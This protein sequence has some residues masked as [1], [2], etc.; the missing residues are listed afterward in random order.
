MGWAARASKNPAG[1]FESTTD[2]RKL[3]HYE[4]SQWTAFAWSDPP[5]GM[6]PQAIDE[7][8]LM[9]DAKLEVFAETLQRKIVGVCPHFKPTIKSVR[10]ERK[11]QLLISMTVPAIDEDDALGKLRY[12]TRRAASTTHSYKQAGR[13][14]RNTFGLTFPWGKTKVELI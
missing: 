13:T 3:P 12:W 5:A 7:I 9:Q 6:N 11:P 10:I 8:L 14:K 4:V 1:L 2:E